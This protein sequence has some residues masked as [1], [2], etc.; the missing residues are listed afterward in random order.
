MAKEKN[1]TMPLAELMVTSQL[2]GCP[3]WNLRGHRSGCF[4]S[5]EGLNS[6]Q[7]WPHLPSGGIGGDLEERLLSKTW[8]NF[9]LESSA[10]WGALGQ[11]IVPFGFIV[12][13]NFM[14]QRK[15]TNK[16]LLLGHSLYSSSN[17]VN[18]FQEN[19]S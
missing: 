14:C 15:S 3:A 18:G 5:T 9:P 10:S 17:F 8:S 4:L 19:V 7:L 11:P 16:R 2:E 1:N 12:V 13:L 6:N